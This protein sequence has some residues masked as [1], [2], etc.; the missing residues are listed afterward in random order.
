MTVVAS[1]RR[2][3]RRE[4]RGARTTHT[5]CLAPTRPLTHPSRQLAG[6]PAESSLELL[7]LFAYGTWSEYKVRA[8]SLPEL[9][10]LQA[11]K[12][13]KLSVVALSSHCKVVP[14]DLLLREL[15]IS[16]IREVEN[17]LIECFYGGLLQGKLD[18]QAAALCLVF[19]AISSVWP[20]LLPRSV[21]S[22]WPSLL[23]VYLS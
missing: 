2:P 3:S 15:E 22:P 18:Q 12:L 13:K 23:F 14:Y 16:S 9:S 10:A 20:S 11:T 4:S 19:F 1:P 6:T 5:L 7:K 17:L 8:A 21:W